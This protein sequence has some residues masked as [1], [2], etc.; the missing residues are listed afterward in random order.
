MLLAVLFMIIILLSRLFFVLLISVHFAHP[1]E[2]FEGNN[3][4]GAVYVSDKNA[5]IFL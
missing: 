3:A 4:E 2:R 1:F 5:L